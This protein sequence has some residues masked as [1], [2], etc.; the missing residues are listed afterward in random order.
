MQA[1]RRVNIFERPFLT[2]SNARRTWYGY[3]TYDPAVLTKMATLFRLFYNFI[4][5]DTKDKQTPAMR[6]GLAK[7]PV[8]YEKIIYFDRY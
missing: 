1:R 8:T 3:S 4:N 7:G 5:N 2:G 6:L